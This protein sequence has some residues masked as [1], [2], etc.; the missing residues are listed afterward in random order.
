[1]NLLWL[2][3]AMVVLLHTVWTVAHALTNKG[4]RVAGVVTPDRT[5]PFVWL[6]VC[7]LAI[8]QGAYILAIL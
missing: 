3:V 2:G 1:M 6:A 4:R 5:L 7:L 8:W